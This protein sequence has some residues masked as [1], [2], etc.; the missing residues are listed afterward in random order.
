MYYVLYV[1]YYDYRRPLFFFIFMA[2][3]CHPTAHFW[4]NFYA[5]Q[6]VK[7]PLRKVAFCKNSSKGADVAA[8]SHLCSCT[9]AQTFSRVHAKECTPIARDSHGEQAASLLSSLD[10]L[11]VD[12]RL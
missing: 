1:L 4:Q 8:L 12:S 11:L 2:E 10:L 5:I 6:Q 9:R 7:E 3:V